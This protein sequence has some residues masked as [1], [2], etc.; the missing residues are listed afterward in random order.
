MQPGRQDG[1]RGVSRRTWIVVGLTAAA[2][3][4]GLA[5]GRRR[6]PFGSADSGASPREGFAEWQQSESLGPTHSV[7]PVVGDGRW[8]WRQPPAEDRGYLEPRAFELT[9]TIRWTGT[10]DA[11]ELSATTVLPPAFDEQEILSS[12]ISTDGCTAEVRAL[13]AGASQLIAA[14]PRIGAGQI[15]EA[16][17]RQQLRLYKSYF[18]YE[19]EQFPTEQQLDPSI[20]KS[21]LGNSPGIQ[22]RG[23]RV[24]EL[25]AQLGETALHPWD[26]ARTFFEWTR[27]NIRGQIGAYT[28]VD[29]ALKNRVGD[30][31][32]LAGV[33]IALCR[34]S[35]IPA[36]LVWVPNHAWAEFYLVDRAGVGHWIPAHTAAYPWF[37]WTGVHEVVLQKGDRIRLP[38][39]NRSVRL[40]AD[41][42]RWIGAKP[43][44]DF[45]AELKPLGETEDAAGPGARQKQPDGRWA[46]VRRHSADRW[47]RGD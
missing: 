31:E 39:S 46:L 44:V 29:E 42:H 27:A 6:L 10:G 30:C 13:D 28:S 11:G 21:F 22:L 33:F 1:T 12:D 35:G 8:I 34:V 3:W 2:G 40:L 26:R 18:A 17:I 37:G 19:R 14:S 9:T 15:I 23:R 20:A 41:W 25:A 32:E 24:R 36:R 4:Y 38:E 43:R 16:S 7:T 45:T 5:T 47:M